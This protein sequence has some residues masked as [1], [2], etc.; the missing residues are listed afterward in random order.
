MTSASANVRRESARA[1]RRTRRSTSRTFTRQRRAP[2]V[3]DRGA[4]AAMTPGQTVLNAAGAGTFTVAGITV[5]P[6]LAHAIINNPAGFYFNV[7]STLNPG[8]VARGRLVQSHRRHYDWSTVR[9]PVRGGRRR[10]G[11]HDAGVAPRAC[12]RARRRARE[13]RRLPPRLPRR[14]DPSVDARAHARARPARR[15]PEAAAPGG[16]R[17][18]AGA[19]AARRVTDRRLHAPADAL[20]VP[21]A[22]AAVGLPRLPRRAGARAIPTFELRMQA[23]VDRA[24]RGGRPRR[25]RAR[26]DARRRRRRSAP[27]S[28]SAPTAGIRSCAS[29]PASQVDDLGAPIDVLWMRMSRRAGDPEPGARL[30]RERPHPRD[31]RSRRLLAVRVRHPEGRLRRDP[32]ARASTRFARASSSIVPFLRDRV[33]ELRDW[34][35]DQAADG[36]RSTGCARGIARACC[37]SA[38]RRTRCRR[39]AASASTSR[40][41]TR[42]RRRTSWPA[43]SRAAPARTRI[44]RACRGGGSG[45]RG[46]CSACR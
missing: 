33:G 2:S 6:A 20:Q 35:D 26:E 19:S 36:R 11:R 22:D 4:A 40:F 43:R 30:R 9:V 7:H 1:F 44:S 27:I 12:R 42:W 8:G 37:A 31:A 25:G 23:E 32:A 3:S 45:R 39:S 29:G 41:R 17:S 28:S 21:R 24:D 34:D 38:T 16:A 10:S 13:A 46:S 15:V 5:D 18:S 14:H